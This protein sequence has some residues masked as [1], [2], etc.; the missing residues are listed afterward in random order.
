MSGKP[1]ERQPVLAIVQELTVE[2]IGAENSVTAKVPMGAMVVGVDLL[3]VTAFNTGGTT[4]TATATIGDGTTTFV[5]AQSVAST[6]DKTV[7]VE[8]KFYPAGGE[9]TFS[10]AEGA[11][12]GLVPA[13]EGSAIA[14]VQYV[15]LGRSDEILG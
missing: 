3:G 1:Y 10:L 15:Q 2:N 12:S 11:A 4:P 5:N 8:R 7:A 6:G 14:V 9:I 13:T